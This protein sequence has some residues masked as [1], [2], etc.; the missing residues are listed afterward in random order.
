VS[1]E[2]ARLLACDAQITRIL[3]TGASQPL[4]LGRTTRVVTPGQRKAL[5]VRDGGCI[6]CRA[7]V[8][9]CQA[10]HVT[11][12]ADGGATDLT[13]LVLVCTGCHRAIHTHGWQ[14][15][16]APNGTWTIRRPDR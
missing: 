6:G 8:A 11:H 3:T 4:N 10:H 2:A 9:W 15:V 12:W 14:P 7:P 16:R 13:N 5:A 1:G